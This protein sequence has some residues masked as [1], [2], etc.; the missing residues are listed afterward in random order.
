MN[1][2]SMPTRVVALISSECFPGF[3]AG[4]G[5]QPASCVQGRSDRQ[6]VHALSRLLTFSPLACPPGNFLSRT[7][8]FGTELDTC[9][10]RHSP[11]SRNRNPNRN[12]ITDHF[13]P[14]DY[15]PPSRRVPGQRYYL[16]L[17]QSERFAA[18]M[19]ACASSSVIIP[20]AL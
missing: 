15:C 11:K 6:P 16:L 7:G 14:A 2:Q 3:I 13:H 20:K 4:F 5:H 10:A 9:L 8:I 17:P 19:T 12:L 18:M 1:A